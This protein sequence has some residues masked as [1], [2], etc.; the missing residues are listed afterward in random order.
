MRST[1]F[2]KRPTFKYA[3]EHV[4]TGGEHSGA[5]GDDFA[6]ATHAFEGGDLAV[7]GSLDLDP[8][9]AHEAAAC[10]APAIGEGEGRRRVQARR[11]TLLPP[12]WWD[13]P[14]RPKAARTMRTC[15]AVSTRPI[16]A[17]PVSAV[18]R[19]TRR[20]SP[21]SRSQTGSNNPDGD[22]EAGVRMGW[23]TGDL[24]VPTCSP[25]GFHPPR[26]SS[27]RRAPPAP[28]PPAWRDATGARVPARRHRRTCAMAPAG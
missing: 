13:R 6:A 20:V 26:A 10:D 28:W 1:Q 16:I 5:P 19:R 27:R 2:S 3:F 23:Q 22:P 14:A 18:S 21:G 17:S 4:R 11:R 15:S 7:G 8:V 25:F 12:S 24:V 9:G